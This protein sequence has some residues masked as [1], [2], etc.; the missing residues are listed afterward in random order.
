MARCH[1]ITLKVSSFLILCP[2]DLTLSQ[3]SPGSAGSDGNSVI[4]PPGI[5]VF[6]NHRQQFS[7]KEGNGGAILEWGL[8]VRASL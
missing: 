4:L 7:K 5:Q 8:A 6:M 1:C 2:R 3:P